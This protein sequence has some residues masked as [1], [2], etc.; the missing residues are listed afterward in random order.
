ME[1]K[2]AFTFWYMLLKPIFIPF[3]KIYEKK[4]NNS[5]FNQH[6]HMFFALSKVQVF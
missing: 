2:L 4:K 5:K 3:K 6:F 1:A